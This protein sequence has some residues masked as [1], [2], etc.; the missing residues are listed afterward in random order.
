[1]LF[2]PHNLGSQTSDVPLYSH[3]RTGVKVLQLKELRPFF[4]VPQGHLEYILARSR[5]CY[6]FYFPHGPWNLSHWPSLTRPLHSPLG[7]HCPTFVHNIRPELVQCVAACAAATTAA[8]VWAVLRLCI[9]QR[10]YTAKPQHRDRDKTLKRHS[11]CA[12]RGSWTSIL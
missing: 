6:S 8:L 9:P 3:L 12:P 11:L 10:I 7:K 5:N 1:M 2:S 4:F